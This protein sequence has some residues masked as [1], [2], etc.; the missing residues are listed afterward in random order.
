MARA[1]TAV[2]RP[3]VEVGDTATMVA[4]DSMARPTRSSR[5]PRVLT[6]GRDGHTAPTVEVG[7]VAVALLHL[8]GTRL[9]LGLIRPRRL[10]TLILRLLRWRQ[11]RLSRARR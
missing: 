1:S 5:G 11:H 2:R 4:V 3:L 9:R 8:G 6:T 10:L 7:E